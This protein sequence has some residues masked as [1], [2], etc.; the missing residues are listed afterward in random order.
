MIVG[1][2]KLGQAQT[3]GFVCGIRRARFKNKS[4]PHKI[5][6]RGMS[7]NNSVITFTKCFVLNTEARDSL[8]VEN[9]QTKHA[10]L[11]TAEVQKTT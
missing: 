7:E 4:P 10:P 1:I 11:R 2:Y 5:E 6:E 9:M 8:S 3:Y